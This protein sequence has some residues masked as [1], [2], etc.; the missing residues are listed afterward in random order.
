MYEAMHMGMTHKNKVPIFPL[1]SIQYTQIKFIASS[2]YPK[3]IE[4]LEAFELWIFKG[5]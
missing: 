5:L 4:T 3:G 1:G 2:L